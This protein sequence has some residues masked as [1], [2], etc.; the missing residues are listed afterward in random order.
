MKVRQLDVGNVVFNSDRWKFTNQACKAN[1]TV[2]VKCSKGHVVGVAVASV[3]EQELFVVL[4]MDEIGRLPE[5]E[6]LERAP[7]SQW[8]SL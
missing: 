1:L 4:S 3:V 6:H 7:P 5:R 2:N 8:A